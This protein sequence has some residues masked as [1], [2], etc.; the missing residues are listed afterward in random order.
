MTVSL[1]A[2]AA[3]LSAGQIEQYERDGYLIVRHVFSVAEIALAAFEA[4]CLRERHELI[5]VDNIRCRWQP[6][7]KTDEC[8]FECFDPVIDIGLVC[9]RVAEDR[10]ILGC[11]PAD[12]R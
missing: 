3:A 10:R 7:I 4:E 5:H 8:L 1:A 9:A 12:P 11:L 2:P 6:H